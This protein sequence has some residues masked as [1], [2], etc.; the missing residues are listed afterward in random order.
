MSQP[1]TP[2]QSAAAPQVSD[3]R[4]R[5]AMTIGIFVTV[6]AMAFEATGVSTAMPAAAEDLDGLNV[7]A[8][9]FSLFVVGMLTA[10]VTAG[11]VA[12]RIGPVRPAVVGILIFL[13]GLVIAGT[14]TGMEQLLVGRVVQGVGVG[15]ANLSLTVVVALAYPEAERPKVMTWI[16]TAWVLPSLAGPPLAAWITQTLS[17]HWV[18]LAIVPLLGVTLIVIIPALRRLAPVLTGQH[19]EEQNPVPIWSGVTVAACAV[20]IQ[21]AGQRAS[22]GNRGV[23]EVALV[24]VAVA[25]L[26]F[27]LPKMMPARFL[28]VGRGL[29][30]TIISRALNAGAYFG[31]V[32]FVPLMLVQTRELSLLFAG[33]MVS[34]AS[35]GWTFGAWL[36]ARPWLPIPRH[37]LILVGQLLVAA[38]CL[39]M[40]AAAWF[41]SLWLPIIAIL[42]I[43]AGIGMG[44]SIAS[45]GLATM[46]FSTAAQQGRN[47]SSLQ[48]GEA[49][50]NTI[51][52]GVAGTVYATLNTVVGLNV[53][54]T[55]L[56]AAMLLF[57]LLGALV[58]TRIGVIVSPS[59]PSAAAPRH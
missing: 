29:P 17:W 36:Q 43:P 54:F 27:T 1:P 38:G 47:S 57:A 40:T 25:G 20:L 26:I 56:M 10:T 31:V 33:G 7:Y 46:T 49:L 3:E 35:F 42:W 13:A 44:F 9:A 18:F 41:S 2:E 48:V 28:S 37:R 24:A 22:E 16:S 23:V 52:V 58:S 4:Q 21:Y 8:W 11:R 53:A 55:V 30:A 39:T 59:A 32:S 34:I 19:S 50:G 12:D 5:R 15:T 45:T 6:I 51:L 14:A